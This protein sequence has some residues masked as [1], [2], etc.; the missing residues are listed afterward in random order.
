M[1]MDCLIT[2]RS[3]T[4]GQR[5]QMALNTAGIEN[6]LRRTPRELSSRGCGYCLTVGKNDVLMATEL[7]RQ[8]KISY[9]KVYC[10]TER[11]LEEIV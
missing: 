5:G 4:Y 7:L 1:K 6:R 2:F 8:Q 3:V 10:K 11:G 9:G